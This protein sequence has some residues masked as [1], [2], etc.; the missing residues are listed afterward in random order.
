MTLKV[1]DSVYVVYGNRRGLAQ[2]ATV[3][4]VGRKWAKLSGYHPRVNL[5]DMY[6]DGGNYSSPGACWRSKEEYEAEVKRKAVWSAL[7]SRL[8]FSQVPN[9]IS[10]EQIIAIAKQLG[11]DLPADD[12][13]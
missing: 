4:S 10:A 8:A 7:V 5:E 1:G 2:Y 13:S 6:L 9:D 11:I 12:K 3:E